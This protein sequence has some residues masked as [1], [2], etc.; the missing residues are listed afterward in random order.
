MPVE[1]VAQT[2]S[3]GQ[4]VFDKYRFNNSPSLA[5]VAHGTTKNSYTSVYLAYYDNINDEIRFRCGQLNNTPN[6]DTTDFGTF[7]SVGSS[8]PQTYV[9]T[10]TLIAGRTSG[11]DTGYNAGSYVCLAAVESTTSS[12]SDD[13]IVVV[14]YDQTNGSMYYAYSENPIGK[15][16]AGEYTPG[17][18]NNGWQGYE[19]V[20]TGNIGQ[21]CK[22]AVDANGGIHA[23]AYDSSNG[24]LWYAYKESYNTGTWTKCIVDSN[25]I[26]GSEITLDVALDASGN[27]VPYIGY[28]ATSVVRPKYAWLANPSA[29][30]AGSE[31]D[32]FTGIWEITIVPTSSTVPA[33]NINVGVW[34]DSNGARTTSISKAWVIANT[35][36]NDTAS[37]ANNNDGLSTNGGSS[38]G[39]AWAN[40][41]DNPMMAYQVGAG[42]SG[43]LET[44]QMQ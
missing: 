33:D 17:D 40:A 29:L 35:N 5:T 27:A 30:S 12:S 10:G 11:Y 25:G 42:S 41:T 1:V 13:V 34:K 18:A 37:N 36:L 3:S 31:D 28:Y 44:A 32:M 26:V 14:W 7:T 20:F 22:V 21:Y 4:I 9:S 23:V 24:D 16:A 38:W 43:T 2:D 8:A 39:Y 19:Q 15:C 6:S